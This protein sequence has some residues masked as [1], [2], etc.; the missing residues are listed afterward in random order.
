MKELYQKIQELV[1]ENYQGTLDS[2]TLDIVTIAVMALYIKNPEM[3]KERIPNI[4]KKLDILAGNEK[5]S[6]YIMNKYS[7]YPWNSISDSESAMVV[8][9]L[10]TESKPVDEDWTMAISTNEEKIELVDI[11]A[12]TIHELTHLLRF[13]GIKETK[14]EI[15]VKDGICTTRVDKKK[16]KTVKDHY[17][18]EEGLVEKHTKETMN[19][20]YEYLESEKD[21]SFSPM[22]ERFK[23]KFNGDYKNVYIL[24]V[25]LIELLYSNEKLKELFDETFELSDDTPRVITYIDEITKQRGMFSLLSNGLDRLSDSTSKGDIA[26]SIRII[27]S[28]KP[29]VTRIVN[30]ANKQYTNKA[31]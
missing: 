4:L 24:E 18:F 19:N 16:H 15:I 27:N 25:S 14:R 13:G 9:A 21:L 28:L 23:N 3:V 26:G 31:N 10:D 30:T 7:N 17:S 8:R 20:F 29:S 1:L 22:L 2:K 12:K 6:T 5:V 11:I